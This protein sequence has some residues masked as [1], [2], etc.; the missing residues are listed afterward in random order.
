MAREPRSVVITG[1]SRGLGFATATHLYRRGWHVIAAMRDPE[2]GMERLRT[3][4]AGADDD[5]RLTGVRV[6]LTDRDSIVTAARE[7]RDAVGAP[8]GLVH[9]AGISIAGCVE[10]VPVDVWEDLFV[11]NLFGP[12]RLT[13][14]L[15][16]A[17]R[18][19]GT[20]RI[21]V[22]SSLGGV[23]GMPLISAYSAVKGACERWAQSLADEIAAFGLGVTVLVPGAFKTDIIDRTG[24]YADL[25]GPYRNQHQRLMAAGLGLVGKARPPAEFAP[26]VE[27]ALDERTPFA[28][29]AVGRDARAMVMANRLLPDR[30]FAAL[31]SRMM[32]LPRPGSLADDPVRLEPLTRAWHLLDED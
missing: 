22:I 14:E 20:G 21:I 26:A 7:I 16:P 29:H 10:E 28:L 12:V 17:M 2:S 30:M 25:N 31:T 3:E 4:V 27:R 5:A 13:Q 24:T 19:A 18:T 32:R 23:R 9:N 11:T 8:Y 1:A 6:D 15:L